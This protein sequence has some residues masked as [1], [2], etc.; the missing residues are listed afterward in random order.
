[1]ITFTLGNLK[2][3]VKRLVPA[4]RDMDATLFDEVIEAALAMWLSDYQKTLMDRND[5]FIRYSTIPEVTPPSTGTEKINTNIGDMFRIVMITGGDRIADDTIIL[6]Q[7]TG[8]FKTVPRL[9][10]EQLVAG[11]TGETIVG[12]LENNGEILLYVKDATITAPAVLHYNYF[13]Q[14]VPPAADVD[15]IP[16]LPEDFAA[17]VEGVIQYAAEG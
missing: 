16:T 7:S 12:F 1:M 9:S 15:V 6:S 17:C 4:Y 5:R 10:M 3:R 8:V 13:K 11:G 2:T 14:L